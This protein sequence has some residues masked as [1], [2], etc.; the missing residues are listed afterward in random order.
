[1]SFWSTV[2]LDT[3]VY[4]TT[5]CLSITVLSDTFYGRASCF[6]NPLRTHVWRHVS[7]CACLHP[8]FS[9]C[10]Q[11]DNKDISFP[12]TATSL[13]HQHWPSIPPSVPFA[14]LLPNF[15]STSCSLTVT[16]RSAIMATLSSS[17]STQMPPPKTGALLP[18]A[19]LIFKSSS[20][21]Y[22]DLSVTWKSQTNSCN[23]GHSFP[24]PSAIRSSTVFTVNVAR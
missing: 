15:I 21:S 18:A 12:A 7:S 9:P 16:T 17:P 10:A 13:F 5:S 4:R 2:S 11:P 19:R 14:S 8:N 1:V 23:R 3:T 6:P 20:V 24:D 22:T